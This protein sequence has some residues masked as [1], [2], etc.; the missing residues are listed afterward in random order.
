[1]PKKPP[2]KPREMRTA[3]TKITSTPTDKETWEAAAQLEGLSLSTWMVRAANKA[4]PA[5]AARQ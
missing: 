2:P 5:K 1:M 4:L 3:I